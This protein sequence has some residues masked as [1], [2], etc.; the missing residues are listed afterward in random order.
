VA[1]VIDDDVPR[2]EDIIIGLDRP[3][4]SQALNQ[5]SGNWGASIASR[6][7]EDSR[8]IR[9]AAL[10]HTGPVALRIDEGTPAQSP[11]LW[12][13]AFHAQAHSNLQQGTP[14]DTR[15]THGLM[16]GWTRPVSDTLYASACL[17]AQQRRVWRAQHSTH[18][19]I[20]S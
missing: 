18:A 3:S 15:R 13:H 19:Q 16:L 6:L 14:A 5:L 11:R 2:L 7:L 12:Q 10:Q 8:F 1:D 4:A 20:D 17:G 9:L